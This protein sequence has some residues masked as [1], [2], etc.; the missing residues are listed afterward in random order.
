ML[1]LVVVGV[2]KVI[3]DEAVRAHV[4]VRASCAVYL[5]VQ[6]GG[7][8][9]HDAYDISGGGSLGYHIGGLGRLYRLRG[10]VF[11]AA[12]AHTF[13]EFRGRLP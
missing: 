9:T 4:E 3:L 11:R 8:F 6:G 2:V 13:I 7:F 1:E 5:V 10:A 12:D